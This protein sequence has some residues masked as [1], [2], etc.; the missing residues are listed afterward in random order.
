MNV[1]KTLYDI[2]FES[3]KKAMKLYAKNIADIQQNI[4]DNNSK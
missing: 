3:D 1:V 4:L 2:P